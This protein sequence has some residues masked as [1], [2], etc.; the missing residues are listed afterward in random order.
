MKKIL[1]FAAATLC[2]ITAMADDIDTTFR[3]VYED[4]TEIP[5]GSKITVSS[6]TDDGIQDPFIASGIYVLNTTDSTAGVGLDLTVSRIDNGRFSCCFP[7][8]CSAQTGPVTDLDNGNGAMTANEK[9]SMHTEY[10]PTAYGTCTATFRIRVHEVVEEKLSVKVEDFVAYGPSITVNFVYD[11][12][13]TG[14]TAVGSASAEITG[15]YTLSGEKLA[16]PQ[17]GVNIVKYA[18]GRAVKTIVK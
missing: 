2:G 15:Y 5:D 12:T 8:S 4:G 10:Y 9:R 6:L 18:D 1:L 16:A 14:I 11:E 3:F 17:K 13:S 7:M